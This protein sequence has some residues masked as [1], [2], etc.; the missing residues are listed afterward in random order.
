MVD[1]CAAIRLIVACST[2]IQSAGEGTDAELETLLEFLG[3]EDVLVAYAAKEELRKVLIRGRIVTVNIIVK[4][5]CAPLPTA[6][7]REVSG[8][9]FQLLR[10][11]V[12]MRDSGE[13][14]IDDSED[15]G[16]EEE[17]NPAENSY[18]QELLKNLQQME[19]VVRSV[20]IPAG[21]QTMTAPHSVQCEALVF[22]SDFVKR[23]H[24]LD[25]AGRSQL[26]LIE[27]MMTLMNDVFV[28][29]NYSSQ[30]TFVSC[31]VLGLLGDFQELMK[32]WNHHTR[33]DGEN[34]PEVVY[35]K[36]LEWCL[37]WL[38]QSSCTSTA[39]QFLNDEESLNTAS[40][41]AFVAKTSP[42]PF[43]QQWLLYLSRMGVA[44]IE[45]SLTQKVSS[46]WEMLQVPGQTAVSWTQQKVP[47]RQQLFMVLAEQDDMMVEVLNGLTRMAVLV[48]GTDSIL[49]SLF[50][51][52][53]EH[54]T[55]EY[56]PDL[57]FADLV[58]TLGQ[59]HLVLL[60]L[61]ISNETQM[62][63]YLMRYLRRLSTHWNTS[64]RKLQTEQRLEGV[65]SVLIRLRLEIDRLVAADLFPYSAGPLTRRLLAVEQ[66]YEESDDEDAEQ[67]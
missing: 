38:L 40:H 19:T 8:F 10:Q 43:L 1:W 49:T 46:D 30:P 32:S 3:H 39:L 13:S 31:A 51:S 56:D 18:V 9:R 7:K 14:E 6:W 47:S 34:N 50:S 53:I 57:L 61:L 17:D 33:A 36:W 55:T 5:L 52:F 63:E 11:F 20:F 15:R 4:V 67:L 37:V 60:D 58:D 45:I 41:E 21:C 64:Q 16:N 54:M 28:T 25:I 42:Y 22:M 48:D 24:D 27:L 44:F 26:E 2:A 29:M 66:L 35:S 65:M 23:L 59:D 12:K 62:L